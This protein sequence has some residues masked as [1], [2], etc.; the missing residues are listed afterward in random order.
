M[1]DGEDGD[2]PASATLAVKVIEVPPVTDEGFGETVVEV[3]WGGGGLTV[4][5]D[6]AELAVCTES[7][8]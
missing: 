5:E 1:P 8:E 3:G 7:A 2:A 6:E 4:S